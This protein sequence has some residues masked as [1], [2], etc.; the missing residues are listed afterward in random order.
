MLTNETMLHNLI[1]DTCLSS[2]SYQ[3]C[4]FVFRSEGIVACNSSKN[5][6][7]RRSSPLLNR[8]DVDLGKSLDPF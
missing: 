2:S 1:L 7:Q 4:G 3:K 8:R 5:I 6:K